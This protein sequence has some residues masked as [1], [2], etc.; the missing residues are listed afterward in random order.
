MRA[1]EYQPEARAELEAAVLWYEH[2]RVGAGAELEELV[3]DALAATANTPMPGSRVSDRVP[4]HY[5]RVLLGDRPYELVLDVREHTR[6]VIAVA[7]LKRRPTYWK[8]R[9]RAVR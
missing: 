3:S 1:W 2:E 5:R 4:V 9:L 6:L 8:K 7:H